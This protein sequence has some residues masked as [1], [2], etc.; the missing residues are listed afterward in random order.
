MNSVEI[1]LCL[2]INKQ[3]F[4]NPSSSQ[5]A[6]VVA[7]IEPYTNINNAADAANEGANNGVGN[8]VN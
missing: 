2:W 1:K 7:T 4:E 5:S 8:E 3:A 6:Q